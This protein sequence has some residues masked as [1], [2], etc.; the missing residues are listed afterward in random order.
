MANRKA[1]PHCATRGRSLE[2]LA[3]ALPR[4]HLEKTRESAWFSNLSLPMGKTQ[5]ALEE[6]KTSVA[7]CTGVYSVGG[8]LRAWLC[9]LWDLLPLQILPHPLSRKQCPAPATPLHPIC[10]GSASYPALLGR[11][12]STKVT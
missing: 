12:P 1:Q 9:P 8:H 3:G 5:A 11:G 10:H 6:T 7:S 2:L 4:S